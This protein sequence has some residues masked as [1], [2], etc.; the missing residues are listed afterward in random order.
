[1]IRF[2]AHATITE[3]GPRD[4][5][6]SLGRWVPTEEKL[7]LLHRLMEAGITDIEAVSFA[8]PRFIPELRDAEEVLERLERRP[9]VHIRGLVPNA[10]GAERAAATR[11]DE[12]VGLI[13][14]SVAYTALNQNTTISRAVEQAIESARIA[15]R[16]GCRYSVGIGMAFWCP[17][18]GDIPED[19]VLDIVAKLHGAGVRSLM[20]AGSVG[21]EDPPTV[22]ARFARVRDRHPDVRLAYH[23]HDQAGIAPANILAA[24]DA[25]VDRF[26]VSICGLGGGVA[27]PEAI[28][29]MPTEDLVQ[30]MELCG[31]ATGMDSGSV[32]A[33]ARD[34][35]QRLDV[36]LSSRAGRS[37]NR[38][39]V[40]A[41]G[42]AK[43]EKRNAKP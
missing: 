41:A 3:V 40:L 25:G 32:I 33:A 2:P 10:K 17:I 15:E 39:E 23:V 36:P 27:T 26:E 1:V 28:G 13:T 14:A 4:G 5:L 31:V 42:R 21:M 30:M 20:L 22:H 11:L 18:E 9:G 24:L 29:N 7:W 8:H 38:A 37:G 35:A 34:I 6:Q 43:I 16:A 19:R 12:M